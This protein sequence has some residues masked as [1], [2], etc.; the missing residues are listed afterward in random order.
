MLEVG[1]YRHVGFDVHHH[2]VLAVLHRGQADLGTDVRLAGGVHHHV[3]HRA[4]AHQ[5]GVLRNGDAFVANGLLQR[6]GAIDDPMC[7]CVMAG[8]GQCCHGS[9][10][11]D[12]GNGRH[13]DA[14]HLQHLGHDVGTHHARTD[15]ADPDRLSGGLKGRQ[16]CGQAACLKSRHGRSV[17]RT[18]KVYICAPF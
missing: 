15:Q 11:M 16:I 10:H 13:H 12:V 14:A 5:V 18:A 9:R 6:A 2:Q 17:C 3:D 8:R 1:A 4:G 7:V